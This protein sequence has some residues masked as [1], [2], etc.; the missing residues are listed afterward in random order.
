[1]KSHQAIDV[2]EFRVAIPPAIDVCL[3]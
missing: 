3:N 2:P 1:M